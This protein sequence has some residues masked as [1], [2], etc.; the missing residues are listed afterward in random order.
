MVKVF[1]NLGTHERSAGWSLTAICILAESTNDPEYFTAAKRIVAIP[2][3]E[4]KFDKGGAWPHVLPADHAGKTPVAET[5]GNAVFLVGT[6]VEGLR[7]YHA[8]TG[9][10]A[11]K[12]SLEAACQWLKITHNPKRGEWP[13]TASWEGKPYIDSNNWGIYLAPAM[14]YAARVCN[15]EDFAET[16]IIGVTSAY[17]DS[18]GGFGKG[19]AQTGLFVGDMLEE[20]K[21]WDE[22]TGKKSDFSR[23]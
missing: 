6:V 15:R 11:A 1:R 23:P 12:K 14:L 8:L 3:Q 4:Q 22:K 21:K 10:P 5:M 20:L 19:F 16:A 18:V 2:L 13:Y 17:K 9:D 7:R